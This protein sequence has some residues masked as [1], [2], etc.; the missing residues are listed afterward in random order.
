MTKET[1]PKRKDQIMTADMNGMTVM[2]DIET[3]KYYNLGT[4]GGRIWELLNVPVSV[5]TLLRKLLGEYD[6]MPEKCE[7]DTLPFLNALLEWGLL[8]ANG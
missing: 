7:A 8:T 1:I 6:V 4:V 2:M 5:E 3:G